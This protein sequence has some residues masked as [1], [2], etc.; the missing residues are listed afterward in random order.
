MTPDDWRS[1]LVYRIGRFQGSWRVD[2]HFPYDSLLLLH[3]KRKSLLF[4]FAQICA[5]TRYGS[6]WDALDAMIC[7]PRRLGAIFQ[8]TNEDFTP[9]GWVSDIM[10][11]MIGDLYVRQNE[12]LGEIIKRCTVEA[13][14]AEHI[15]R[16]RARNFHN[17]WLIIERPTIFGPR[18]DP[19]NE[20]GERL[21]PLRVLNCARCRGLQL[22]VWS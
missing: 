1:P 12:M 3:N 4:K 16:W 17:G 13:K 11:M 10:Q 22:A 19:W 20:S 8:S 15:S 2:E 18:L 21:L 5:C 7:D 14:R 9:S 6:V